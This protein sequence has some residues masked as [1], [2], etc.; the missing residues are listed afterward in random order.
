[1]VCSVL[2]HA[3]VCSDALYLLHDVL[4]LV[5]SVVH[6]PPTTTTTCSSTKRGVV[7]ITTTCSVYVHA[8]HKGNGVLCM[9]STPSMLL[10]GA[11]YLLV[12]RMGGDGME[13]VCYQSK[14]AC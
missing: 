1:M 10:E 6:Q 7:C 11:S 13:V 9:H 12:D 2:L 8:Q 5:D 14:C 3:V 4:L